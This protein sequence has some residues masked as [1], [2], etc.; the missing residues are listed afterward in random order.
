MT[1][2]NTTPMQTEALTTEM[3]VGSPSLHTV[4][5][6][7]RTSSGMSSKTMQIN[8]VSGCERNG[9]FFLTNKSSAFWTVSRMN[10]NNATTQNTN[11]A[12]FISG[13]GGP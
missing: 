7:L 5:I 10:P 2:M 13:S 11:I 9:N 12:H 1:R 6:R 4:I 3:S 8:C